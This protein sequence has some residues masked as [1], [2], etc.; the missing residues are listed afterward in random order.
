[1]RFTTPFTPCF[2][3]ISTPGTGDNVT[4]CP[5]ASSPEAPLEVFASAAGRPV[6]VQLLPRPGPAEEG[7]GPA[8]FLLHYTGTGGSWSEIVWRIMLSLYE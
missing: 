6:D 8:E 2:S 3:Y 7:E 5:A 4:V 1:M